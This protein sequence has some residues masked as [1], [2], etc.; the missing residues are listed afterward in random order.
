MQPLLVF[1]HVV[2]SINVVEG[3]A[4]EQGEEGK[5][6]GEEPPCLDASPEHQIDNAELDP[7]NGDKISSHI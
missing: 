7:T 6:D 3:V 2:S 4:G 1:R 5:E